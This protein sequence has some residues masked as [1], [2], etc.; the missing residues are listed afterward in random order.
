MSKCKCIGH[1]N[2]VFLLLI[3]IATLSACNVS[4]EKSGGDSETPKNTDINSFEFSVSEAP[5]WTALFNRSSGWF[6]GDGIFAIP[7]S[8]VDTANATDSTLFI[9]S[10]TMVGEIVD[11]EMQDGAKMTHNSVAYLTGN[12][13][14]KGNINFYFDEDKNG[15]PETIFIPNTP[16]SQKEDYYWLGDGFVNNELNGNTYIFGYRMRNLTDDDWSFR[17]VGLSIIALNR[18]SRPPFK[19]HRQIETPFLIPAEDGAESPM[20]GAGVF[21]NTKQ[22]GAPDPDGYVYVYG[23]QGLGKNLIVS[24]VKPENFEQFDTWRFW[25]GESWNPEMQKAAPVTDKVSNELSVTP[26]PDGRYALVFQVNS[27]SKTV[28][29]R[30]G[31]SPYGP[32]G[33]I[34]NLWDC[35]EVQHKNYITY[36]AK[37]YPSFSKKGELLISY[38][39]NAFDFFNELKEN[40]NLYRPRFIRIKY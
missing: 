19:D 2:S 15:K 7:L 18:G 36:N 20:L 35:E 24:R 28:G 12:E 21:V 38:N 39:V 10:D 5:E 25:D 3:V 22:A 17:Q 16:N 37:A 34:I 11:G 40:P 23:V 33:P 30:L 27:M 29:L 14:R 6:G 31:L 8:G 13:P 32:F 26:L 9:F 4:K 1:R